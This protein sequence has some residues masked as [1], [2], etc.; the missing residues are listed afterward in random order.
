M[1]L[2]S[3]EEQITTIGTRLQKTKPIHDKKQDTTTLNWRSNWQAQRCKV[4][5]QIGSYLGLQQHMN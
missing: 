3:K 1:F 2:Y 4:L 5:E